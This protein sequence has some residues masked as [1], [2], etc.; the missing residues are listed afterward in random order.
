[1]EPF[2]KMGGSYIFSAVP[3]ENALDNQLILERT[4]QSELSAWKIY[5]YKVL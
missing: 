5:L 3:I 2:K 1:M 4:F